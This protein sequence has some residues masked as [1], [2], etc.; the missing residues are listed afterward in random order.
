MRFFIKNRRN[1]AEGYVLPLILLIMFISIMT[2]LEY[3][4]YSGEGTENIGGSDAIV[5]DSGYANMTYSQRCDRLNQSHGGAYYMD[6]RYER[7]PFINLEFLELF[8]GNFD[9]DEWISAGT[10]YHVFPDGVAIKHS[11]YL[12]LVNGEVNPEDINVLD[13][14][15][16]ALTL[17]FHIFS[18]LG[19]VGIVIRIFLISIFIIIIYLML[20]LTG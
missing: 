9:F 5:F 12:R 8:G 17:N 20:P 3:S 2:I 18:I 14:I 13:V 6:F 7:I 15:G 11:D 19:I 1:S 4:I 10:W 16:N